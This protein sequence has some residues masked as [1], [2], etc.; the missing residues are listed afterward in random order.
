M[1]NNFSVGRIVL[2]TY[3]IIASGSC[4]NLFSN[5]LRKSIE[6]NRYVQQTTADS[7]VI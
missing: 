6:D 2:S 4:V 3:V 1:D 5:D 7:Q